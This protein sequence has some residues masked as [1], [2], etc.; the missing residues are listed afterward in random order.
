MWRSV[1]YVWYRD[2]LYGGVRFANR[3]LCGWKFGRF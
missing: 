1:A 2:A 3:K